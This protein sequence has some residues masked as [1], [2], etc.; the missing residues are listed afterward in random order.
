[1]P[2]G[3]QCVAEVPV[4]IDDDVGAMDIQSPQEK[5]MVFK[6]KDQEGCGV[7]RPNPHIF[8]ED[9]L[10][11]VNEHNLHDHLVADLHALRGKYNGIVARE[12]ANVGGFNSTRS[13]P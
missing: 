13:F 11:L 2:Q 10:T 3:L 6:E 8:F 4:F 9:L 5:D 12:V 1:V 7:V